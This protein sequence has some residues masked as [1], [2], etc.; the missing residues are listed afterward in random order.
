MVEFNRNKPYGIVHGMDG[1]KYT[2]DGHFFA[3]DFRCVSEKKPLPEEYTSVPGYERY[4]EKSQASPPGD[5]LELL[6]KTIPEIK[7]MLPALSADEIQQLYLSE[8]N[9]K[10]RKMLISA[11]DEYRAN[12][13]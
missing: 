8:L 6:D 3:P 1:V 5:L 13:Q 11:I 4:D 12:V 9:G 2:Q 10:M 7:E